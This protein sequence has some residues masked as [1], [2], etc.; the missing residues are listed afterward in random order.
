[1]RKTCPVS[2]PC[3]QGS[4]RRLFCR[5][6]GQKQALPRTSCSSAFPPRWLWFSGV[7]SPGHKQ[8]LLPPGCMAKHL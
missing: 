2:R 8:S 1:M 4:A 6:S 5:P 7:G 3:P